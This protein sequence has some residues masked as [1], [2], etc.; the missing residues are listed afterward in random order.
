MWV[1]ER[2]I[3]QNVSFYSMNKRPCKQLG[4]MLED[5]A[6]RAGGVFRLVKLNADNERPF[7]E[8]L[9][10]KGFPTVYAVKNGIITDRYHFSLYACE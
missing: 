1:S 6:V 10:A 4:P 7:V 2:Y 5:A 9:Q 3:D 8:S